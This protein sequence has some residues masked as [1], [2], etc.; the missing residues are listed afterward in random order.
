MEGL[1]ARANLEG[2]GE[3]RSLSHGPQD[4]DPPEKHSGKDDGPG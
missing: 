2:R 1:A 3:F 4:R